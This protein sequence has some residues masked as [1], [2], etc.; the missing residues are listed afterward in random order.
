MNPL[1]KMVIFECS[2]VLSWTFIGSPDFIW[3]KTEHG[4]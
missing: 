4:C 2:L 3:F 1:G